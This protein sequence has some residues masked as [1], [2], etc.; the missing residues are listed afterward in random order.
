MPPDDLER[1]QIAKLRLIAE[2]ARL[3]GGMRVLEIGCGWGS[4]AMLAAREYGAEVDTITISEEQLHD[5]RRR[6]E[7]AGLSN[8]IR[9]H[10]LDYRNLPSSFHHTFD[11]VVSIGVMEHGMVPTYSRPCNS[12]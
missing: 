3:K 6:I 8:K 5:V 11:A 9:V 2:R 4:F 10:F 12:I 1:G 7:V